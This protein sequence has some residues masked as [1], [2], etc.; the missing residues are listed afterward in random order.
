MFLFTCQGFVG[1]FP[2]KTAAIVVARD[3]KRAEELMTEA[4]K[5]SG[6]SWRTGIDSVELFAEC[7]IGENE[8]VEILSDGDY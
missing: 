8:R 2:T 4:L 3:S 6:L 5:K 1:H 7:H